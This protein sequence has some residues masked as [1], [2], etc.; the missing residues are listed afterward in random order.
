VTTVLILVAAGFVMWA[1]RA[2]AIVL[3]GG[4]PFPSLANRALGY[5]KHAVLAALLMTS[6]RVGV[7]REGTGY[8]PQIG[9]AACATVVA[10]LTR[11]MVRTM[12][13]GM[14]VAAILAAIFEQ[15]GGRG[16]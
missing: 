10:C 4:R 11:G 1:L 9:A 15:L 14:G 12:V 6:L 7:L 13:A 8:L 3:A 16:L 5:G 2:S